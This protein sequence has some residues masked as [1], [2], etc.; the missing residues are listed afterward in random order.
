LYLSGNTGKCVKRALHS[1]QLVGKTT[2][3]ID[4]INL[5][6]LILMLNIDNLSIKLR[7]TL[8]L[9]IVLWIY[10]TRQSGLMI[11]W[12]MSLRCSLLS[13]V[14][15]ITIH[16]IFPIKSA[17]I[18]TILG[19][20]EYKTNF[21]DFQKLKNWFCFLTIFFMLMASNFLLLVQFFHK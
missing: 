13:T 7:E 10:I 15:L 20:R 21:R 18:Y 4:H 9:Y 14:N 8:Y 16:L 19:M 11:F 2:K 6:L 17:K 1:W 5:F 12:Q 3:S